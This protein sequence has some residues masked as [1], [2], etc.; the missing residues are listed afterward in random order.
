MVVRLAPRGVRRCYFQLKS[1][2]AGSR[3]GLRSWR[4]QHTGRSSA[5]PGWV[6]PP[7]GRESGREES[8]C[9]VSPGGEE[10]DEVREEQILGGREGG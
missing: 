9:E 1:A 6:G 4:R 5:A 8:E 3:S 2:L 7:G 10:K